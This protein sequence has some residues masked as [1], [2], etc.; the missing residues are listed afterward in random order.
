MTV[1]PPQNPNEPPPRTVTT[2]ARET[3]DAADTCSAVGRTPV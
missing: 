2:Q 3:A 1:V